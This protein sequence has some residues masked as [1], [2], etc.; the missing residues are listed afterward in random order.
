MGA[1]LRR[2]RSPIED[3]NDPLD[4]R[5]EPLELRDRSLV[6]EWWVPRLETDGARNIENPESPSLEVLLELPARDP[7]LE[8]PRELLRLVPDPFRA[9]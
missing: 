3:A 9:E 1:R 4:T 6:L 2:R 5:V 7:C 8:L